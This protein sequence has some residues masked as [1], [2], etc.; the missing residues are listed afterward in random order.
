MEQYNLQLKVHVDFCRKHHDIRKAPQDGIPQDW[1][2]EVVPE[3]E[4][5]G[6]ADRLPGDQGPKCSDELELP[7]PQ[8]R[9]AIRIKLCCDCNSRHVQDACPLR[10]PAIIIGD[11]VIYGQW[12]SEKKQPRTKPLSF[13]GEGTPEKVSNT[14]SDSMNGMISVSNTEV[15]GL[16]KDDSGTFLEETQGGSIPEL[17][18]RNLRGEGTDRSDCTTDVKLFAMDAS[19]RRLSFAEESL[20]V[21]LE[22]QVCDPSHGLSVVARCQLRQYTQFGPL[23]G[24]P[25]KEMDIPDD[26]SMK[27]IW[28]VRLRE[29]IN[30]GVCS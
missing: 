9:V 25:I 16:N 12:Q 28:E 11:A 20:P 7:H 18:H 3:T 4:C 13:N 29:F 26:F 22:L 5:R 30:A 27:D 14:Q 21:G 24:Q 2:Q 8:Q 23:V 19:V 1:P 15:D 6:Q 17:G 10:N